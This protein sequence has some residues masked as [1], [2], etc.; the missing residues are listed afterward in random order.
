MSRYARAHDLDSWLHDPRI[1][2][3]GFAH[4]WQSTVA[5][6]NGEDA[7]L[8]LI[9]AHLR[10]E[11]DVLDIGCGHGELALELAMRCRTVTGIE[12]EAGYLDLAQ[13]LAVERQIANAH[14]FQV[15][16]AG[17]NESDRPFAAIPLPDESIDLFVNRR[18]PILR[19]YLAE[20]TR[21][22]RPGAAIVGL[23]PAGNPPPPSWISL[24][25]EHYQAYFAPWSHAQV[26][27]WVTEP[28]DA[29]GIVDYSVWWIDVPEYLH[30]PYDVYMRVGGRQPVDAPEFLAVE[31]DFARIVDNHAT[32]HG[33][34]LR[35]QR[36]LWQAR[37]R[38]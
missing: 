25:P 31:A 26:T 5:A 27:E 29:A 18:G 24:L 16:L 37:L 32:V 23:H 2:E 19:R 21:V 10:P 38:A 9:D 11:F 3:R 34:V 17:A 14:F 22:A 6:G 13:E 35:H 12:R 8:A 20:A 1:A 28:L 36:L 15:N 7:F 30:A 4:R 33:V